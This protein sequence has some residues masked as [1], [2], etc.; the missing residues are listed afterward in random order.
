MSHDPTTNPNRRGLVVYFKKKATTAFMHN[1]SRAARAHKM[2]PIHITP[3]EKADDE[4]SCKWL[5]TVRPVKNNRE[6]TGDEP[7]LKRTR[8]THEDTPQQQQQLDVTTHIVPRYQ[9]NFKQATNQ[10]TYVSLCLFY[11]IFFNLF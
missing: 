6:H 3:P 4:D 7:P 2:I 5:F 8:T 11:C 10:H 1:T 9:I